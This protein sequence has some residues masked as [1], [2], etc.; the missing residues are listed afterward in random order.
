VSIILYPIVGHFIGGGRR[1]QQVTARK[2]NRTAAV[3]VYEEPCNR[4]AF[5]HNR[6]K[7]FSKGM[8]EIE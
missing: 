4:R 2:S 3:A 8:K 6:L 7:S 5:G 1:W